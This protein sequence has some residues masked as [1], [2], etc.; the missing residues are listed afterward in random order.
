[1]LDVQLSKL[2]LTAPIDGLVLERPAHV[3]EVA[4]PGASLATLG[5]L[6]KLTLTL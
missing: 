1:M 2:T 5:D 6:D 3:G 4:V